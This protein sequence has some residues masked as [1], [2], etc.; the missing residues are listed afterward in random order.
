MK[1]SDF[2]DIL[3]VCLYMDDLIFTSNNASLVESFK[4]SI[5]R[6]FEM[7][8]LGLMSYFLGIEVVQRSDVIF[9]SQIKYVTGI[10]QKFK[11]DMCNLEKKTC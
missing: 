7:S 1:A 2:G 9:I 5:T 6:E 8:E 4:Q 11:M 10:L 3:M